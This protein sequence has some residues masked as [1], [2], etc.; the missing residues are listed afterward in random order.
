MTRDDALTQTIDGCGHIIAHALN[1]MDEG[2]RLAIAQ[3]LDVGEAL[4]L[5]RLHP[6]SNSTTGTLET[7]G[8]SVEL[9]RAGP[10]RV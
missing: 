4:I 5:I 3:Q 9:F 8:G 10:P 7:S 6:A 1:A 2:A